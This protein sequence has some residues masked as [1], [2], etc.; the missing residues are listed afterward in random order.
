MDDALLNI[1]T[2]DEIAFSKRL[3]A[4]LWYLNPT[5]ENAISVCSRIFGKRV[6]ISPIG[7]TYVI[8]CATDWPE[9]ELVLEQIKKL[10]NTEKTPEEMRLEIAHKA[11][12]MFLA[13]DFKEYNNAMKL[14][15][16]MRGQLKGIKDDGKSDSTISDLIDAIVDPTNRR[17][18][19]KENEPS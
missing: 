14:L 2:K 10:K 1:M 16:Q 11:E 18:E 8:N 12:I 13:G 7:P 15:A 6:N 9:D 4:E 17:E 19:Y 5:R 3:F